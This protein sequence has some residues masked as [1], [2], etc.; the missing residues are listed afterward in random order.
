MPPPGAPQ[1]PPNGGQQYSHPTMPYYGQNSPAGQV[2]MVRKLNERFA[3]MNASL[4]EEELPPP[5][6]D[7]MGDPDLPPP[8]SAEELQE[9]ECTYSH[10]PPPVYSKPQ[11]NNSESIR[12][13]LVSEL[14]SGP[15][16]RRV[17]SK[18]DGSEC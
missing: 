12:A 1:Y 11:T 17:S 6:P 14:K 2:D 10:P 3:A 15:L 13:S 7:I 18:D 9:I 8:P 16:L 4:Q 5:P